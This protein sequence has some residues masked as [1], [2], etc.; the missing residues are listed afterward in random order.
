MSELPR[1]TTILVIDDDE[2]IRQSF[3]DQLED[4]GYRALMAENGRTGVELIEQQHP[5]LVMTDLRMPEMDGL[6]VI[7]HARKKMPDLPIIV[8]SGAGG[9]SDAVEALRLGAYDY[10]I[11]PVNDL[12]VLEHALR[13][14]LEQARLLR[15]NRSYQEHLE[16]LIHDRTRDLEHANQQLTNVNVR[17]RK[18]VATASGLSSCISLEAFGTKIL[19]EFSEHMVASGGCVYLVEESGLRLLHSLDPGHATEFLPFPLV[20]NSLLWRVIDSGKPLLVDDVSKEQDIETSGWGG[21]RDGSILAFPIP[22]ASGKTVG[23]LALHSKATPP[24]IEQDKEIGAIL[25]SYSSET[26]RAAQAFDSLRASEKQYR[27]LFDKTNDAIFLLDRKTGRYLDVNPAVEKLTGRSKQELLSLCIQDVAPE[28]AGERL[29]HYTEVTDPREPGEWGL[30][31]IVRPDGTERRLKIGTVSAINKD[32]VFGIARDITDERETEKQLRRSQKMEAV[33]QLSG[34][35]AHDFNNIL[36]IILGNVTLLQDLVTGNAEVIKRVDAIEKSAQRAAALTK[37]LLGF[38]REQADRASTTNINRLIGDMKSLIARSVTPE[39]MVEHHFN[40]DLW[41]ANIDPSDFEDALLNL[42]INARDAMPGGG[43]LLL[44]TRNTKLAPAYCAQQAGVQPGE[45]V[46]L[47]T[48]DTGDGIPKE[49]IERVF[50]PFFTTKPKG[51]GTGLGLA[52]VF[53]FVKR[54]RGHINVYSELGV[55]TTFRIYLP[56]AEGLEVSDSALGE[57]TK[58]LPRGHETILVVDDEKALLELAQKFLQKQGYRVITAESGQ[59]ALQWLAIEPVIDLLFSDVVMPG[60]INGYQLAEQ[61]LASHPKLRVLLTSG[62]TE[63]AV[64]Q[65]GQA[66]FMADLLSKPY[67]LKEL[68]ARV[69]NTLGQPVA[70]RTVPGQTDSGLASPRPPGAVEWTENESTGIEVIDADHRHLLALLSRC[71]RMAEDA[72]TVAGGNEQEFSTLVD[73]LWAFSL[74]HFDREEKVMAACGYPGLRNHVD[75]HR[76]MIKEMEFKR[77]QLNRNQ[78]SIKGLLT[79][80]LE[81]WG[82]HR[83]WLDRAYIPYCEGK[84]ELIKKALGQAGDAQIKGGNDAQEHGLSDR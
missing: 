57:P 70:D 72:E 20:E 44:E 18:I 5:D 37:Q 63:K 30:V 73:Q 27:A 12:E 33:G 21:Y 4:L 43:Q 40:Q 16:E 50:E 38:S 22:D 8:I 25:S 51:K 24:F 52:M 66:H 10:L 3:C 84:S 28:G 45:Y 68:A 9:V 64:A 7:K 60:G 47:A 83:H 6:D 71:H 36:G 35:I 15:Q 49:N 75:V 14:A 65:N 26:L 54:S 1:S 76:L 58:K 39:V 81:S 31:T 19:G 17:L 55:G 53:G 78:L 74:A 62:Y 41:S 46:E 79:Y 67:D 13:K 61:A 69:R 77:N 56:R 11:K 80:I 82:D 2:I 48:S 23:V 29:L 42:V 34:G 59:Q 32:T